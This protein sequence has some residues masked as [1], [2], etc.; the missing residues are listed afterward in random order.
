MKPP[1]HSRREIPEFCQPPPTSRVYYRSLQGMVVAGAAQV[2]CA[3]FARVLD[4]DPT[5]VRKDIEMTGIV[6]KPRVGVICST[7]LI[8]WLEN[9]LG[10]NRPKEAVLAGAGSLGSALMELRKIP[11][12]RNADR[13]RFRYRSGEDRPAHPRPRSA[14][15]DVPP[16]LREAAQDAGGRDRDNRAPGGRSIGGES[17]GFRRSSRASGTLRRPTYGSRMDSFCKTK[18][19]IT[20]WHLSRSSWNAS[21]EVGRR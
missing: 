10:W 19:F 21:L 12:P 16:G 11:P 6:G 7:E 17:D 14:A 4:L 8:L 9:F 13:R 1:T 20:H 18:I 15:L 5:Q 3:D 2:S